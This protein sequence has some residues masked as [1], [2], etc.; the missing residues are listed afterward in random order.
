MEAC[1]FNDFG[2][3]RGIEVRTK[4]VRLLG[5]E[6]N[7]SENRASEMRGVLGN[8]GL[9]VSCYGCGDDVSIDHVWKRD[10]R[11]RQRIGFEVRSGKRPFHLQSCPI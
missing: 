6:S 9:R 2:Q 8:N 4:Y 5:T 1:A 3:S 7:R 10:S 11:Q